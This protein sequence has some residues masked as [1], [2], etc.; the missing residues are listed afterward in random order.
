MK[1]KPQR[2]LSVNSGEADTRY[3]WTGVYSK[4]MTLIGMFLVVLAIMLFALGP[5]ATEMVEGNADFRHLYKFL[6]NGKLDPRSRTRDGLNET[7]WNVQVY[8]GMEVPLTHS[9][10]AY[11]FSD[12][13][14]VLGVEG[15]NL[16]C[17]PTPCTP[18][19]FPPSLAQHASLRSSHN[20]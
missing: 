11:P 15:V 7:P 4:N 18:K 16:D 2:L 3:A 17:D 5:G 14:L 19:A 8:T 9:C 13:F 1:K 10:P 12:P 20:A 6:R